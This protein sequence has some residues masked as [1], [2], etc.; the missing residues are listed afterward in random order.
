MRSFTLS[1]SPTVFGLLEQSLRGNAN[2]NRFLNGKICKWRLKA[3]IRSCIRFAHAKNGAFISDDGKG[4]AFIWPVGDIRG[5]AS[6]SWWQTWLMLPFGR[7]FRITRFQRQVAGF[8]P[9]EPHLF[10]M[11]LAVDEERS[12]LSAII[13]IRDR[14]FAL[15]A[16]MQLPVYAQTTSAKIR[17]LYESYGFETYGTLSIPGSREFI[18][19]LK[20]HRDA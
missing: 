15:S 8:Q 1:E 20:R 16:F 5:R 19:F 13:D 14:I 10:F 9:K 18:Y 4:I 7:L 11:L 17:I 6:V 2:F 12:G 3:Y